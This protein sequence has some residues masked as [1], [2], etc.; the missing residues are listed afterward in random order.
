M[1]EMCISLYIA[2]KT[3]THQTDD[4]AICDGVPYARA[5]A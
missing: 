5:A 4:H 1:L 2:K 3:Q